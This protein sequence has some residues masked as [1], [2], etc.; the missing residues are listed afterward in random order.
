MAAIDCEA[1]L[2]QAVRDA[3]HDI[4]VV[5]APRRSHKTTVLQKY[6]RELI[7][8]GKTVLVLTASEK[9]AEPWYKEFLE[10]VD[11][12]KMWLCPPLAE[13]RGCS[14]DV[15]LVDES[16]FLFYDAIAT[17]IAPLTRMNDKCRVVMVSS[18]NGEKDAQ[19]KLNRV[20]EK[21]GK[22]V[23]YECLLQPGALPTV[24]DGSRELTREEQQ[25]M[26]FGS[27]Q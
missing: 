27:P 14:P 16:Q 21:L 2:A 9:M 5:E 26:L 10:E 25:T 17:I 11:T 3:D 23:K 22:R 12:K 7:D 4:I 6:A 19:D 24:I 15:I 1:F 13:L 8:Q 18:P 20:L